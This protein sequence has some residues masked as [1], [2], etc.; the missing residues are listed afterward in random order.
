MIVRHGTLAAGAVNEVS[1]VRSSAITPIPSATTGSTDV[2][3][4]V[5][6]AFRSVEVLNRGEG[7]IFFNFVHFADGEALSE[8]IAPVVGGDDCH[9][10]APGSSLVAP[11]A[12]QNV[13]DVDGQREWEVVVRL[14]SASADDFSVSAP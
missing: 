12:S 7:D 8:P 4:V 11:V 1:L 2:V 3:H 5:D 13:T 9:V 14:I 10:V 6:R